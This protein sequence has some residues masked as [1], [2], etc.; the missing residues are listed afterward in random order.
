MY[1][2]HGGGN[3]RSLFFTLRFAQYEKSNLHDGQGVEG[4]RVIRRAY[5]LGDA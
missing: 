5:S 3:G 4:F 2:I 1:A